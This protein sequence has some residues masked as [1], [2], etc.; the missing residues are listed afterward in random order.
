MT[1][2]IAQVSAT[3]GEVT[4]TITYDTPAESNGKLSSFTLKNE[5]LYERLKQIRELLGRPLTLQDAKQAL[6]A[7]V[8]EV[9]AEKSSVPEDFDFTSVIGVELEA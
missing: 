6:G 2:K 1:I 5:D 4:L 7:I 8:N 9:R 3:A